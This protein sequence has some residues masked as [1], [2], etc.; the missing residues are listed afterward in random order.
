MRILFVGNGEEYSAAILK[1]ENDGPFS[2][3]FCPSLSDALERGNSD[4]I[5]IPA[6]RFLTYPP[7]TRT[8]PLIA[9]GPAELAEP[10]FEAGCSDFIREPWTGDELQARIAGHTCGKFAFS[11]EG[12]RISGHT[13]SGPTADIVLSDAAYS[14]L[15]LL[16][17]NLGQPVPRLAI[18]S[19]IGVRAG[20]S[21]SIDMRIARL[22]KALRSAGAGGMADRL[23]GT[24]GAYQLSS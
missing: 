5:V 20:D 1:R 9:S 8:V 22:R 6:L 16:S 3:F 13:L 4:A 17:A 24:Q 18:A 14:I 7:L 23:R 2:L 11:H 15:T 10:C 21:R 19:L 12:L